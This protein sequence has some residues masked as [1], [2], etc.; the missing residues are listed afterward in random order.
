MIGVTVNQR[1]T[2]VESG[3]Q[4]EIEVAGVDS[5]HAVGLRASDLSEDAVAGHT[6]QG[7]FIRLDSTDEG[8]RSISLRYADDSEYVPPT[9]APDLPLVKTPLRRLPV[10][11]GFELTQVPLRSDLMPISLAWRPNGELLVGSL[12]GRVWI[13]HDTDADG[14]PDQARPQ[15]DDLAAPYGI[16]ATDDYVDVV[17]KHS[18]IRLH[19]DDHDGNTDRHQVI[20]SGWGHTDDYHDWVVGL[21]RDPQG[22]YYISIPCQQDERESP[23]AKYRGRVL[24]LSPDV[25]GKYRMDELSRGHRFPMGIARNRA[26]ELFVTDNQGNYNPFNE[27]NHVMPR[28]HFGFINELERRQ[29][30]PT[31]VT[32]PAI[33]I[34]HPWTR[35]VNGICFLESPRGADSFGPFEGHLVGCEYDTRRLIRMSL[36]EVDGWIQGAAYPFAEAAANPEDGL[37]GPINCGVAPDGD[38]YIVNIRDSGWGGGNN[39]G[40]LVRAQFDQDTLPT[41]IAEVVAIH[42]GFR[43]SFTRPVSKRRAAD[44]TNY[45]C[46]SY[47]RI[48]TP[49]YGGDD[50]DRRREAISAI[51]VAAD[52]RSVDITLPD[53]RA[54][55]VYTWELANLTPNKSQFYPAE[56]YYSLQRLK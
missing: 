2:A 23:A 44:M 34:P 40:S 8:Q 38:L 20:A 35:S 51:D 10:M 9:T 56:A 18:L 11:P 37:L 5:A 28:R 39:T 33:W 19:D 43:I 12:K 36:D 46:S 17:N 24:R 54:G 41:G 29:P 7:D 50:V 14:L 1:V 15:S 4:R 22:C 21:P 3:W 49:A 32:E 31:K 30:R 27:L 48:S 13:I 52:G 53:L 26:G 6:R 55:Y 16:F 47:R 25:S 45:Q 42:N